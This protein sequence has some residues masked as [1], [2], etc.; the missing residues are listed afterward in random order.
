MEKV[1]NMNLPIVGRIQHGENQNK[2]V[3]ELRIF[4]C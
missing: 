2:R 4:Y 1:I 3:I